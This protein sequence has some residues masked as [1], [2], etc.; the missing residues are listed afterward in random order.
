METW[1]IL[2]AHAGSSESAGFAYALFHDWAHIIQLGHVYCY[3]CLESRYD[4]GVQMSIL[5]FLCSSV[6]ISA[7]PGILRHLINYKTYSHQTLHTL[8]NP[9]HAEEII[10]RQADS[11]IQVVDSNSHT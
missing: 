9:C 6:G 1:L 8:L 5:P 7:N 11:L 10:V 4:I 2:W 3:G